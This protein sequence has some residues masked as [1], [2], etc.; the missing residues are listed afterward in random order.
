M[1]PKIVDR[2]Q[3]HQEILSAA[4]DIFCEKG[5]HKST[6]SD[7]S[8]AAGIGQGTL[9]YYF[10]TKEEIFWG[11]YELLMSHVEEQIRARIAAI[12]NQED[13][14]R[15]LLKLLF[16][17]FPEVE[18][19]GGAQDAARWEQIPMAGFSQVIMEFWLQAERSGKQEAFYDRIAHQQNM[20]IDMLQELLARIGSEKSLD[21]E[22]DLIAHMLM[23]LRDGLAFQLRSGTIDKN[24][25]LLSRIR[26]ML[27][28][29]LL[30][31][32]STDK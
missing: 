13:Q 31:F 15:E 24:S 16:E 5:Y 19:Y 8:K 14:L 25:D 23:A 3:R 20:V 4:F 11:V 22:S 18:V 6:L 9:Y 17:N 30:G 7:I 21:F 2:E 28:Q 1:T 32:A 29:Y 26:H 10:P 12:E 27:Q